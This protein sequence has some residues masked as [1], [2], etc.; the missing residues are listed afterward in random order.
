MQPLG[1]PPP[2]EEG[3]VPA[4]ASHRSSASLPCLSPEASSFIPFSPSEQIPPSK[5]ACGSSRLAVT[6]LGL[7]RSVLHL[8]GGS[9]VS[10]TDQETQ[11]ASEWKASTLLQLK[12]AGIWRRRKPGPSRHTPRQLGLNH[13]AHFRYNLELRNSQVLAGLKLMPSRQ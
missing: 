1:P 5:A 7:H 10:S 13:L 6:Y 12:Q 3:R 4:L 2:R 11:R 9:C 8:L